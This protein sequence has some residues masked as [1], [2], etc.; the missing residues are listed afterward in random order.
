ME[1]MSNQM[2]TLNDNSSLSFDSEKKTSGQLEV[3]ITGSKRKVKAYTIFATEKKAYSTWNSIQN[4]SVTA[5]WSCFSFGLA[6]I[7]EIVFSEWNTMNPTAQAI[8]FLG[9]LFSVIIGLF[10]FFQGRRLSKS[11]KELDEMIEQETQHDDT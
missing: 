11:A 8:T 10:F 7:I 6:F 3:A 5:T 9:I 4:N 2:K 1:Q